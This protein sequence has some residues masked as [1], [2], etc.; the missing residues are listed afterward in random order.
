VTPAAAARSERSISGWPTLSLGFSGKHLVVAKSSPARIVPGGFTIFRTDTMRYGLTSNRFTGRR[1]EDIVYRTSAGPTTGGPISGDTTGRYVIIV[2][3][4]G[5]PPQPVFCCTSEPRDIPLEP[6]G[7]PDAP[8]ATAAAVDGPWA[9]YILR[10]PDGTNTLVSQNVSDEPGQPT[11]ARLTRPFPGDASTNFG[12]APGIIASVDA[13]TR[14]V[15]R[16][17]TTSGT[18]DVFGGTVLPT[19]AGEV[20]KLAVTR[21]MVVALVRTGSGVDLVR[22]D[23]P[24]WTRTTISSASSAPRLIAV[25][26]RTV[27]FTKGTALMQSTPGRVRQLVRPKGKVVSIATDGRRASFAERSTR[28]ARKTAVVVMGILQPPAAY[29]TEVRS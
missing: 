16:L 5:T 2:T 20:S 27:L 15:I 28:G 23:A 25:G 24:S 14:R 4:S 9:R 13:A 17:D 19:E 10:N 7:R 11:F 8:V 22:F 29:V 21:T 26:D 1:I 18:N 12:M 6:D 3:G